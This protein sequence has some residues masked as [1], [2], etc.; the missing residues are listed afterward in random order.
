MDQISSTQLLIYYM[1]TFGSL[2]YMLFKYRR[3]TIFWFFILLFFGGLFSYFGKN[4]QNLYRITVVIFALHEVIKYNVFEIK[5]RFTVIS[6]IIF[7][8]VFIA[9]SFWSGDNFN[10]V[11]SQYS[12]YF[13]FFLVFL[14]LYRLRSNKSFR[15]TLSRVVYDLLIIQIGIAIL[16]YFVMGPV[17][18]LVGSVSFE[19]GAMA[20]SLPMLGFMFLW[21]KRD[22]KFNRNDWIFI[23]G[24]IFIGFVSLKRTIW[25]IMPLII[26]LFMFYIPGKKISPRFII[27]GILMIPLVFYLGVRLNPSLNKEE[28]IWGSFDAGFVVKYANFYMFGEGIDKDKNINYGRGSATN[29]LIKNL[30]EGNVSKEAW[31]GYGLTKM[32]ATNYDE[33]EE[34]NFGLNHKGSATGI[35]QTMITNGYIGIFCILILMYFI[36]NATA[37]RR[38]KIVLFSFFIWEYFFYTGIVLREPALSFLLVYVV[39]LSPKVVNQTRI[40]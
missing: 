34:F 38:I 29:S 12:R 21:L 27:L 1:F 14:I 35:Y 24:L 15:E 4:A 22:G 33:F 32:Y 3:Q 6:F 5:E 19:G 25:F 31:Y 36:I 9:T 10:I 20:T 30:V 2:C 26:S 16:K 11:F 28:R 13:I 17:E 37:N 7:S 40:A 18:S 39:L 23:A 8:G